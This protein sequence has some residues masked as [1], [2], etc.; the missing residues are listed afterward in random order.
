[1]VW[2]WYL[3][4]F[5]TAPQLLKTQR[6]RMSLRRNIARA[7]V[8]NSPGRENLS[9]WQLAIFQAGKKHEASFFLGGWGGGP[10]WIFIAIMFAW[11]FD[12]VVKLRVVALVRQ[13]CYD[14]NTGASSRNWRLNKRKQ[15]EKRLHNDI[16]RCKCSASRS[17]MIIML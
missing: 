16:I 14:W 2:A 3:P 1:M 4:W 11:Y 5:F 7:Y 15:N 13:R 12:G 8:S 6:I 9:L 10:G 17:L